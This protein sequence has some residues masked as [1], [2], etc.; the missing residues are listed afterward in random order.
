[1]I[2][3]MV[4]QAPVVYR[5]ITTAAQLPT[6]TRVFEEA[7]SPVPIAA[8]QTGSATTTDSEHYYGKNALRITPG[9]Q[10]RLDLPRPIAIRERPA[11]GEVRFLRFAVRKQSG[12]RFALG[13][14]S[15]QP[16]E[17]PARYDLGRGEPSYGSATRV[18]PDLPKDWFVVTRDL[19]ADFGEFTLE[20]LAFS[21]VDG[22]AAL[23]DHLYLGRSLA[24]FELLKEK[25]K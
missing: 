23:F 13:L 20:G 10:F 3:G 2:S 15:A 16:R 25:V 24:D 4:P 1:M 9:G 21:A 19:F 18:I 22:Q 14:A 11:W 17:T 8:G 12:G 6:L 5:T 7:A